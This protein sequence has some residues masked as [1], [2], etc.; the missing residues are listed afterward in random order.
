MTPTRVY[1]RKRYI[2]HRLRNL[3][4]AFVLANAEFLTGVSLVEQSEFIS[5]GVEAMVCIN[6]W[7]KDK[8]RVETLQQQKIA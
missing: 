8:R 5:K 2:N 3:I 6:F 4:K 1:I 7:I